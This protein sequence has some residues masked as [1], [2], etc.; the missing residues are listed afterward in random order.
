MRAHRQVFRHESTVTL[1][2]EWI[3]VVFPQIELRHR[4]AGVDR[5]AEGSEAWYVM[6][7]QA[8]A[9]TIPKDRM[10]PEQQTEFAAFVAALRATTTAATSVP[11][12]QGKRGAGPTPGDPAVRPAIPPRS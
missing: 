6:V 12:T 5:V 9:L 2:G 1:D 8:Q 4:W 7:G 3:T 11:D 10:T